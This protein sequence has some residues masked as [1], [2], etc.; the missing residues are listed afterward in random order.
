MRIARRGRPS[1]A[2]RHTSTPSTSGRPRS[3]TTRSTPPAS[4]RSSAAAPLEA[5]S[6][7][8]PSRASAR[9]SGSLI[10]ASSSTTSRR[11]T[12][13]EGTEHAVPGSR[14]GLPN[15]GVFRPSA[16]TA[17]GNH[18][19]MT[20]PTIG[21]LAAAALA[22]VGVIHLILSPEYL[23]EQAYIGVLF[24]AGGLFMC[25]L[26]VAL[27]RTDNVPSW[28]LG[29]LTMAGMGI[30][31]VLSR[32]TGL[33]GFKESAWELSGIVC[34]VL[35]AG[36]VAVAILALAPRRDTVAPAVRETNERFRH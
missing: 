4:R 22:V 14:L 32:T 20:S 13:P 24:I 8:C 30:G 25:G 17:G 10:A 36:F 9:T 1:R 34:L 18:G 5:W 16:W 2:R 29:A 28:L 15:L 3:S 12:E 31:Y 11:A 7:S 6:T 35:E 26:A 27:W 33:P 21:K 23:S 19:C